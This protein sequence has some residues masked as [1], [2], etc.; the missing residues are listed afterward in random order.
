MNGRA[1][2][3]KQDFQVF[4]YLFKSLLHYQNTN[5]L[6]QIN[7]VNEDLLIINCFLV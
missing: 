6:I 2:V 7:T 5:S 4:Q 3:A 1:I